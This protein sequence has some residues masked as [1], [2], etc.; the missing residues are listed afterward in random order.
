MSDKRGAV[1]VSQILILLI[2]IVAIGY[3]LG[4]EAK[5]IGAETF[6]D[7][8]LGTD[9]VYRVSNGKW[10]YSFKGGDWKDVKGGLDR[11]NKRWP[12][13]LKGTTPNGPSTI[14][15][16]Q[17]SSWLS[18][19][20]GIKGEVK[21]YED[22]WKLKTGGAV[23]AI[24]TGVQWGVVVYG[25]V[26]TLGSFFGLDDRETDAAA[27]AAGF[28]VA[29][30]K[31]VSVLIGEKG[32]LADKFLNNQWLNKLTPGQ[33]S[34]GVGTIVG[35]I[36]FISMYKKESTKTI[37][38]ECNPWDAPAGGE[39]CEKCNE[40]EGGLPCSE[41]QCRS[42][43]Q[44]CQLLNQGTGEEKCVWVNRNDVNPPVI[45]PMKEALK[46]DY[47]Y[48]PDKAVSPP[49]RGVKINYKL[50]PDKCV[51][52][53]TPL[54]FGITLDEPAKCRLDYTRKNSFDEMDF[55]FGGSSL[56]KYNHT[57]VMS[58]PGPSAI[59]SENLTIQNNGE[60]DLY[61]R[62]QDANGNANT[63][64]FVFSF[65]VDKGPDTTPPLIVT[66][67]LLNNMPIAY[68]QTSIGLEV[69]VNEPSECRWSRLDQSYENMEEAMSCSK[70]VFEMNAQMLYKC[71]TT[72][73][74]LKDRVKNNFYF[75]C[76]DQPVGVDEADR[77]VNAES[78]KFTL[79][80]SQPLVIDSVLPNKTIKDATEPVKVTLEARTSA[81]YKEGEATC[82]YSDTGEEGD[83]VMFFNTN[84]NKHSQELYLPE[85]EY[86]YSIKCTDLGGNSDVRNT[87][88]FVESD[89]EAPLVVRAYHEET[90]LKIVTDEKAQCVYSANAGTGCS[91]LF[92][93]GTEMQ[94]VDSAADEG[95]SHFAIGAEFSELV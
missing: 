16:P 15:T 68:N 87:T 83:Y 52:A 31:G 80:G 29:A 53:F 18:E 33:F 65:C 86:E 75:R 10:Q 66:T 23:D 28:G 40:Q 60:Y 20:I 73:T 36:I 69:Y 2:G 41:Y 13:A 91:Y 8:S 24:F 51:P 49:D 81:G 34:F 92:E 48:R 56:S 25:V 85:G 39:D 95:A 50:S 58:L 93:D 32:A 54:T 26:K 7:P 90:Y 77:N 45:Q 64:N 47:E 27:T 44:S 30:G 59:A 82:Y 17:G 57:Q 61:V 72:L 78:Y 63:A 79:L 88:F 62:C 67:N 4:S 37:T 22:I 74:G 35:V 38:F 55:S 14:Q 11:L 71:S 6:Q 1:A 5:I 42:L 3:A 76:K 89:N 43:G 46:D 70:S 84:S 12:K 21:G 9:Y 94:S 19:K